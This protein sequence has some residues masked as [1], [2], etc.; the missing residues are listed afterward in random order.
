MPDACSR[1]RCRTLVLVGDGRW[2][3]AVAVASSQQ[4]AAQRDSGNACECSVVVVC[5]RLAV[6]LQQCV[7]ALVTVVE[8]WKARE[9]GRG[10]MTELAGVCWLGLQLPAYSAARKSSEI[11]DSD[12]GGLW[13]CDERCD[14]CPRGSHWPITTPPDYYSACSRTFLVNCRIGV[15]SVASCAIIQQVYRSSTGTTM[16]E[17]NGPLHLL[18]LAARYQHVEQ[19]EQLQHINRT[20]LG[21]PRD[22]QCKNRATVDAAALVLPCCDLPS[23]ARAA[24][25]LAAFLC[26]FCSS[27]EP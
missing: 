18:H 24:A 13:A 26:L 7:V 15:V 12:T 5:S 9:G 16:D 21:R 4:P 8:R 17:G 23:S 2:A 14:R 1:W 20:R 11:H 22:P 19:S 27:W 25:S 3:V 10:E 6:R